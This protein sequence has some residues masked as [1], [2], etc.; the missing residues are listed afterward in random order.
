MT[1]DEVKKRTVYVL[2][3]KITD[4]TYDVYVG[5]T[6]KPME[7]RL[8]THINCS[9]RACNEKNKLYVRM[10]QVGLENW[11]ITPV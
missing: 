8:S 5:S 2:S 7:E 4:E 1:D 3:K 6:S 11:K 9:L 10:R